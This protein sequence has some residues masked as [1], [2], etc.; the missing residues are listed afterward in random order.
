MKIKIQTGLEKTLFSTQQMQHQ[1]QVCKGSKIRFSSSCYIKKKQHKAEVSYWGEGEWRRSPIDP[2]LM[3][4]SQLDRRTTKNKCNYELL[5][6]SARKPKQKKTTSFIKEKSLRPDPVPQNILTIWQEG[7]QSLPPC[8]AHS[9]C[10]QDPWAISKI[11]I[12]E[13]WDHC[14]KQSY[15]NLHFKLVASGHGRLNPT[16]SSATEP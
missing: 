4:G 2:Y 6:N 15:P 13:Q 1:H 5:N 16:R 9:N 3:E 8:W 12:A 7:L 14:R 11:G 10:R